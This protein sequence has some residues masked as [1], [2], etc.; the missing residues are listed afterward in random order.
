M[1]EKLAASVQKKAHL[2]EQVKAAKVGREDSVSDGVQTMVH[3]VLC[4][5]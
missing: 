1:E 5:H 4:C 3:E 2:E